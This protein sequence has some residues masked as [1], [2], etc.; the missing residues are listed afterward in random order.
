[1]I[2]SRQ[3]RALHGAGCAVA[4]DN[5]TCQLYATDAS[6]YRVEPAAVAFPRTAREAAAVIMRAAEA[7]IAITPRGAG[8]GLVAGAIGD[9]LVIDFA[10]YNQQ[11]DGLDLEA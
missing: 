4:F 7:N 8:T 2:P 10:R 9:G 6:I 5:L 3:Q 11:I 1:M